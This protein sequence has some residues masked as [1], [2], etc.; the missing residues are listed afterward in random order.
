MIRFLCMML[1]SCSVNA[2]TADHGV[3]L[4]YHHI[5]EDTP[6]STSVTTTQFRQHLDYLAE[7]DFKVIPLLQLLDSLAEGKA[8]P[9]NAVAITFD[10]AYRSVY[11]NA[12]PLLKKRDLPFTVFVATDA[13]D[14]N[15]QSMMTWS[16]LQEMQQLGAEIGGHSVTHSFLV[17][18]HKNE[19]EH[20]WQLRVSNEIT[21]SIQRLE[22]Q[23]GTMVK[24]FAY[25]Y[26]EYDETLMKIVSEQGLYGLA[27]QSGSVGTE[28]PMNAIPRFSMATGF[29]SMERFAL[30]LNSRPLPVV[31]QSDS[32]IVQ[33]VNQPLGK[34]QL[35][36][37]P[38][39]YRIDQLNCF[40]SSG[41]HLTVERNQFELEITLPPWRVGRNKINCTAPSDYQPTD[42]FWFSKLWLVTDDK[43]NWQHH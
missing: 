3:I 34:L 22:Q 20:N 13:V 30:A 11:D 8:V 43:G 31:D 38:G 29:D 14:R 37:A 40:S 19:T 4:L 7:N 17:R 9:D 32:T 35:Q 15:Y 33:R 36:L 41:E 28:T 21:D 6:P 2:K 10:D 1:L 42:Y 24:S 5:G 25:P 26:G 23:L 27:Q 39:E 12:L 16:Q 18:R